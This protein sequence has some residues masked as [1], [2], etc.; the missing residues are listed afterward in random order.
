MAALVLLVAVLL[1][2]LTGTTVYEDGSVVT[3]SGAAYC[4]PLQA[5]QD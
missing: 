3:A 1:A 2:P 5:C 4:L